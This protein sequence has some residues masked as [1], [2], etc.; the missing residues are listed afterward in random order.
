MRY[1]II[2]APEASADFG[3]LS[4][5]DRATVRDAVEN[6][7]RYTPGEVSKSSVKRLRG[8]RRLQYR[9]RVG[10]LRIYYDIR[11]Q[12]VEILAIVPKSKAAIWLDQFGE[13]EK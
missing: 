6:R 4:A 7:L 13:A 3:Q 1:E 2:F 8:I 10:E 12:T 9:L 11:N 5:Q